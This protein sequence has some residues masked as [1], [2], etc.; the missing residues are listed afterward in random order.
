M[1]NRKILSLLLLFQS[2]C[3]DYINQLFDC[4]KW[5]KLKP[6]I[7]EIIYVNYDHISSALPLPMRKGVIKRFSFFKKKNRRI[8]NGR[9]IKGNWDKKTIPIHEITRIELLK[10][11]FENYENKSLREKNIITLEQWLQKNTYKDQRGIKKEI[12]QIDPFYNSIK[13]HGFKSFVEKKFIFFKY[14]EK[15]GIRISIGRNGEIFWIGSH[16]RMAIVRALKI[17]KIPAIVFYRHYD[18]QNKRLE[19]VKNNSYLEYAEHPDIQKF[20]NE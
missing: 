13:K 20:I 3:L 2:M 15:S 4:I 12:E 8:P 5:P 11:I 19:M 18:W 14:K 10:N 9:V 16:H 7:D 1:F 6:Q 17:K